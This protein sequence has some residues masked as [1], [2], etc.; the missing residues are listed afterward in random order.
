[1]FL[2]KNGSYKY[3]ALECC[4]LL[5]KPSDYYKRIRILLYKINADTT[6]I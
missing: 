6:S 5:I 1:M 2:D 3:Y 4:A